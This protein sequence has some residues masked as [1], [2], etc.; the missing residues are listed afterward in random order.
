MK[1]IVWGIIFLIF[2]IIIVSLTIDDTH[3]PTVG[4]K[5]VSKG[6][7]I[8]YHV[9]NKSDSELILAGKDITYILVH[10][11]TKKV[12]KEEDLGNESITLKPN[13]SN[14]SEINTNNLISGTYEATLLVNTHTGT[15]AKMKTKYQKK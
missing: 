12:I 2:V 1:K 7:V 10:E 3:P 4:L 11:A 9:T 8:E 6:E 5:I 14:I 15:N 13:E